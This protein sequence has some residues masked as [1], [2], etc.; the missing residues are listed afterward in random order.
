[1]DV[2]EQGGHLDLRQLLELL[3][4]R[5]VNEVLVE[6]GPILN[7]ALVAAGL[8]DELVIYY[9]PS[10]LGGDGRAMFQLP[11]VV[12]MADKVECSFSECTRVGPDL[13]VRI[14]LADT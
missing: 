4:Q 13:K 2:A 1:M 3:A 5:E 7:G 8:T 11:Q 12:T 10:L 9:G 6:A 14:L